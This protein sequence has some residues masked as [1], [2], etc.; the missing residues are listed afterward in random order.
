MSVPF[1]ANMS[2]SACAR[3]VA[4]FPDDGIGDAARLSLGSLVDTVEVLE[5]V[6]ALFFLRDFQQVESF[7]HVFS[8][9]VR[10]GAVR[11]A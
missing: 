6:T 5:Q 10:I 9:S 4:T 3:S 2:V 8:F 7:S 1:N 11:L